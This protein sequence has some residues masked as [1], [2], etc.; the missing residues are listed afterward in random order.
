MRI[1]NKEYKIY[2]FNELSE[3][4]KERAINDYIQWWL[5]TTDFENLNKNTNLY[6][7]IK[8]AEDMLTPWFQMQYVW[9][10]CNK[11]ILKNIKKYE[12]YEDGSFFCE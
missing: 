3:E 2:K 12:Y 5:D 6:K 4:S 10:Y 7:A 8:K 1:I 11:D 9:E